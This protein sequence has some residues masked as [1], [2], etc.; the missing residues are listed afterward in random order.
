MPAALYSPHLEEVQISQ[1]AAWADA[2]APNIALGGITSCKVTPHIE[3]AQV[4]DKRASTMP[5]Y[6]ATTNKISGEV[7]M[8]G[9]VT[10]TQFRYFLDAMFTA[11]T[12]TPY[13]YLAA[14]APAPPKTNNILYGQSGLS[15][16]VSGAVMDRLSIHGD[17]NG[18]L[19]FDAHWFGKAPVALARVALDIPT[20][21]TAMGGQTVLSVGTI[22]TAHTALTAWPLTAFSF[23]FNMTNSRS[24]VWHLGTLNPDNF[25]NGKWGGNLK[26]VAEM[27][28]LSKALL[29]DVIANTVEPDGYNIRLKATGVGGTPPSLTM[30][31]S[32]HLLEAP[33][34]FTDQDGVTTAELNFAPAYS[35]EASM[36]S[37]YK[38]A[39]VA[40]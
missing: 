13:E 10:Y 39:L 14:L 19:T 9:L 26:I 11:D 34:M 38:F 3:N 36:L 32:G 24:P 4:V 40:A 29:T 18:P 23:D 17:S 37:C 30:D 33:I 12:S 22:A 8:S 15:Y 31:F 6:I 25:K 7:D 21:I 35:A 20:L 1:E 27:T 2:A 16:A 5:A 28:A